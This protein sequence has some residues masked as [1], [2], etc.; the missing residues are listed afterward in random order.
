VYG[1]TAYVLSSRRRELGLR[2]A[3]GSTRSRL[4]ALTVGQGARLVVLGVV[5]GLGGASLLTE[6]LRGLLFGVSPLDPATFVVVTGVLAAAALG[7]VFLPAWR[8]AGV[9]PSRALRHEGS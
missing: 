7:A 9:D 6:L 5:L 3:L 8:A 2:V 4:L 1:T